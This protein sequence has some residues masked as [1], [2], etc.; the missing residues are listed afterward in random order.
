MK[1]VQVDVS[2]EFIRVARGVPRINYCD[3]ALIGNI[4]LG[5]AYPIAGTIVSANMTLHPVRYLA[6]IVISAED[7]GV[8]AV[9]KR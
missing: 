8:T 6:D 3:P 2:F 9:S 7:G 5:A 4:D 1:F